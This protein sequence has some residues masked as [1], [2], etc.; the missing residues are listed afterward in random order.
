MTLASNLSPALDHLTISSSRGMVARARMASPGLN[1]W[2]LRELAKTP[3]TSGALIADPVIEVAR[4]WEP[5]DCRLSDLSSGLLSPDLVAAL[6]RAETS[7]MP[8][9]RSPYAHQ[10]ATWRAALEQ[11]QSVLVTAGTGAG[12]TECFLIPVLQDCLAQG[13]RGAGIRAILIYPLNALIESQRERLSAWVKG[14]GGRVRFALLNGDTPET[15]REAKVKSDK[16]ELRSRE[17]IRETPPEILVTNITMLEYLL[18]RGADQAI[19]QASQGALRWVVLDEAHSYA[20]SQAAEMA[21][22]LRRVRA[23]FGVGP[24][25]VRLV[26]TSATIGGEERTKEKL[27]A[28]AGALAGQDPVRVSVIE[29]CERIPDLPSIGPE[30]PL[31]PVALSALTPEDL[32]SWLAAHPRVQALRRALTE[33]GQTLSQV[34]R[35]LV[36]DP[37]RKAEAGRLLDFCGKAVWQGRPLLPWRAHLFHRAQGGVWACPDPTCPHRAPELKAEGSGWAFGAAYLAPRAACGCGAPVYEAVACT[38]C[39][40][41][42]LQG[43]LMQGPQ[44]RLDPPDPGEGDDF[45][46]DAEPEE[47]DSPSSFGS[48]GWVAAP[49]QAGGYPGWLS[50]DG[51]WFDNAP[52]AETRAFSLRLID[53]AKERGCCAQAGRAGLMGLR[54][55]PNFLIGN[56]VFGLLQDLAP[57]D[58]RPGLPTGGRRAI[59]FSDSRQGVARLAAKLQQGAERDLTRAYL[60]HAVQETAGTTIDPSELEQLRKKIAAMES[61]GLRDLAEDDR[62]KLAIMTSGGSAPV[63]WNDLIQGLAAHPDLREFAGAIWKGRRVGESMADD[64][65]KIAQM[66]LYRE[67]FR[68]PRIQNNPETLGLVQLKFPAMEERAKLSLVPTPLKEIGFDGEAWAGLAQAA[69]DMIFRNNFAIHLENRELARLINPRRPG[70]RSVFSSEMRRHEVR[71][72]DAIF[73]PRPAG[74]TSRLPKLVEL[75]YALISGDP[76]NRADQDRT[77]E[78]LDALWRL[79]AGTAARDSGAGAWRIDFSR[80]AV[81]RVDQAFLC[82]VVRRPYAYSLAGRSPNDPTIRMETVA[83]PRLPVANRGGLTRDQSECTSAWCETDPAVQVLRSRGLW[84]DLHDRLAAFPPYVRAQEHSAQISRAVLQRYEEDF[85]EG[86]INLLNCSTTMEMGVDL[87]D[88]RLVINANVPPALANYR[89]RAGRAGR[90]GEPWA[91][92]ITFCRDLPLDRRCFDD[93]VGYLGRPIVAPRVWFDSPALVQRHVNA[94]L[95]AAWLAEKGG[96]KVTGSIGAF[97]GA[98]Q[99]AERPVEDGALAEAFLT[100]LDARW[101]EQKAD[102]LAALVGGTALAEQSVAALAART[103]SAF[104]DLVRDW[105]TEHR[106]LLNA[107]AA[108]GDKETRQAMELRAKRLAGEFLLGELARRG[109]TPAYGFPTDVVTFENLRHRTDDGARANSHFKRGTASRSLDQAIREYAPGAEVVIDGLVHK[110]EG[111]LPAW[112]AGTDASGLEDLRTLWTCPECHAFDWTSS[113]PEACPHC[114]HSLEYEKVLRPAGFLGAEP[115]H[116]G[117]ENLAH[118]GTEPVRLSAHGGDWI[119]LPEGAGRMRADSSGRVA[120]ATSGPEGGGFAICLDCGRAHPMAK[121][122]LLIP[123]VIP[124]S[125]RRHGPLLLRRGLERTRDGLCPG[126]DAPQRIQKNIHLAQIKRTD[127]WQWQ[128]PPDSAESAARALAAAL[129]EALA[130]RLGVEPSEIVP[131][132]GGSTGPSGED[133][134][135]AFLHDMAAGGAGLSARM[136]ETEMLVGALARAIE[137][138][139]C[140]EE[141]RRGC[142]ACI[143]RPDLNTREVRLDRPNALALARALKDRLNL[144]DDL[145]VFGPDTRLAGLPAA[146][147]VKTRLRQGRLS[148]VDLWLHGDPATWHLADWPMRPVL[149]HLVDAGIRP[150]IGLATTALTAAGL[151]LDRKLGLHALAQ[152]A[153]LHLVDDL[154]KAGNLPI[155][156]HLHGSSCHGIAV[157]DQSEAIPAE[158]WGLGA[159]APLVLGPTGV[160]A[161]GRRLSA[162]K[163]VELGTGNSHVLWPRQAL[164]GPAAGFAKRFW[165]WLSREAP[166]EIGAMRSAGVKSLHYSDRYLLQ[167]YTLRCLADVIRSAPGAKD[168]E[169]IVDVAPDER[170]PSDSR[171]VHHNF[172]AGCARVDVIRSLL[173]NAQVNLRQKSTIPHYRVFTADL[174]DG[175]RIEMLLDQGFGAWRVTRSARLDFSLHPAVFARALSNCDYGL[176]ADALSAPLSVTM[177]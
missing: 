19:L 117:Y 80:A 108:A 135:S 104:D 37:M 55:G 164:D 51:R 79:I 120:V 169:L 63:A 177:T 121:A 73:W 118:V 129:R 151:T 23:G 137:L 175:R 34:A 25:D 148:R 60:W 160:P 166:L 49:S 74:Y 43:V 97:L 152:V 96:T 145:R 89:Q 119:A 143:L 98:G 26:A 100:D 44:V 5:A 14:L 78:V 58:G 112:E 130:E 149:Q 109:F 65:A 140:P 141:C 163:L 107:A 33:T 54:F 113:M 16:F 138:L 161:L 167:V 22:L 35:M 47:D 13:R 162:A 91:Y 50:A 124:D 116:I 87:A 75:I 30:V 132:A 123:S 150:R 103:R 84:S 146:A 11:R 171:F 18:L 57:P 157:T 158:G 114:G 9:E 21:L 8:A 68:R 61:A 115:A 17:K 102:A 76:D 31:D 126:S 88:V 144:P 64:P 12:K 56:S 85:A 111:I 81:S 72:Q 82:P 10:L 67:L 159:V 52:P 176:E 136:A 139:N 59:S 20:G 128:L 42:H 155:L 106:T 127:V 70:L 24:Q 90:R 94:A 69:V 86:R 154:P 62:K 7:R 110:S 83:F 156:L 92:T 1:Q 32:G 153:D 95:L 15:E 46:L 165:D 53:D 40:T 3:G 142:P 66:F 77:G 172:P 38:E 48:T 27:A 99:T 93:P 174:R 101:A 36:S 131:T 125:M 45:V 6:D 4:A 134:V 41:M 39:G 133:A 28:F 71:T 2:L 173:P 29:G 147:L 122:E 170:P 168:A 105:R